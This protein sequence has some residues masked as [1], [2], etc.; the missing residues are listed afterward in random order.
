MNPNRVADLDYHRLSRYDKSRDTAL[1]AN[2]QIRVALLSNAATQQFVPVLRNLFAANGMTA[3][4]Y[5]APFDA[6]ELQVLDAASELYRFAPHVVFI[7]TATQA[8]RS[9]YYEGRAPSE[10]ERLCRVWDALASNG[11][12]QVVQA[13]FALPYERPFGQYDLKHGQS[14]YRAVQQLNSD[15]ARQTVERRG[16]FICDVESVA[17]YVGRGTWFDD[18]LWDIGKTFCNLEHLPKVCQ[19]LID[20]VL[21]GQGRAIKCVIVDLDDTLWGGIVGDAGPM[22]IEIGRHGPGEP[23][24]RFQ[25]YLLTLKSRGILLAVCS[26]NN[27][28]NVLAAFEQNPEMVL[29]R[30]DFSAFVANWNNKAENIRAIQE[31]L[32]IGFDSLVFLDDNP[33]ERNLIRRLLPEVVVPELPTDPAEYVRCICELNLFECTAVSKEDEQRSEL[34]L[35]EMKRQELRQSYTDI[36]DYLRSL[37]MRITV[38][39]FS[40]P[41]LARIAQLFQRSNQFNLTTQRHSES[42]CARMMEDSAACIP[43]CAS[44][45]DAYGDYGLISIV[46]AWIERDALLLSDWLMSCRVLGRGVEQYLMNRVVEIAKDNGL[47]VIKGEYRATTKNALVKNFWSDFG[48]QSTDGATWIL[49]IKDYAAKV[50]LIQ[51]ASAVASCVA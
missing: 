36:T 8:L 9:S 49:P 47:Q 11:I 23:F 12:A 45:V 16:V 37:D 42:D 19:A 18:R 35:Q 5:E 2:N 30:P 32:N 40:S 38:E 28:D 26:K 39:R 10:V 46:V 31:Q 21:A 20:I 34:Y 48:F 1:T 51:E 50:V 7:L 25:Q 6:I 33:F 14:F 22:G 29:R 17:S 15:M 3:A 43:L 13:N 27:I 44:L 4:I 24:H 41:K